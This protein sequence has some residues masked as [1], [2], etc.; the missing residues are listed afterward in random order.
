MDF[1]DPFKGKT[2]GDPLSN[3]EIIS[4]VRLSLCAEEEAT[5]LYNRIA[6]FVPDERVKK[7]MVDVAKEEQVHIGEFQKLLKL[8]EADEEEL[9]QKGE[10]EATDK[11]EGGEGEEE[12][13][14]EQIA[15]EMDK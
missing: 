1:V 14:V 13:P 8:L 9:L 4:A 7:L 5:H 10:Q 11:I 2:P 6:E 3:Q 15:Q 12:N